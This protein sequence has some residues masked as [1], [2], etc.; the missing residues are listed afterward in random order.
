[1]R[2]SLVLLVACAAPCAL[3]AD[4]SWPAYLGS[5]GSEQYSPLTQINKSNVKQLEIAWT[6]PSGEKGSY[7]FNP[8][9]VEGTMFVL[10]KNN[11]IV[12]LD[13]VTGKEKWVHPNT[14]AVTQKRRMAPRRTSKGPQWEGG[15]T[16]DA[17]SI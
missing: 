9:V 7:L 17:G 6:Y 10:A 12:A 3:A 15:R 5:P 2:G 4:A 16:R 8:T 13:A 14:G 1:M 11:S